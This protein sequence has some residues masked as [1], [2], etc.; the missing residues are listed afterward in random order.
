MGR[1]ARGERAK[2]AT[3]VIDCWKLDEDKILEITSLDKFLQYIINVCS[4]CLYD[5]R[6]LICH[7]NK[8]IQYEYASKGFSVVLQ[9]FIQDMEFHF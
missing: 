1:G 3:F 5:A 8:N 2:G 7:L 4:N 6:T 9:M